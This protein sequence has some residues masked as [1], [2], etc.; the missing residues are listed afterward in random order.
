MNDSQFSPQ[1]QRLIDQLRSSPTPPMRPEAFERLRQQIFEEADR[2]WTPQP[3]AEFPKPSGRRAVRLLGLAA[4]LAV[5]IAGAAFAVL[6]V[7]QDDGPIKE[8]ILIPPTVTPTFTAT[9][10]LTSTPSATPTQTSSATPS[11]TPTETL[12]ATPIPEPTRTFTPTT[13]ASSTWT[14]SPPPPTPTPALSASPVLTTAPLPVTPGG[15]DDEDDRRSVRSAI[16][17]EGTVAALGQDYL[18]IFDLWIETQDV[19]Q[20]AARLTLGTLVRVEGEARFEN[21]RIIVRAASLTVLP[22]PTRQPPRPPQPAPQQT[23]HQP[24]PP[25]PPPPGPGRDSAVSRSS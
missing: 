5:L 15:D 17:V 10:T 13:A 8:E 1:E 6:S 19:R 21:G 4:V 7:I 12:S 9:N 23:A 25:P 16:V 22:P 3:V 14:A 2:I 11:L 20:A 24:P 18:V